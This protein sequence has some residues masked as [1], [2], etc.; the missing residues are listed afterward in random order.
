MLGGCMVIAAAMLDR[1]N[2]YGPFHAEALV[3]AKS[4]SWTRQSGVNSLSLGELADKEGANK[5]G[6]SIKE[7]L[8]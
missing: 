8:H 1:S 5:I 4:G 7:C 6:R 2:G 3:D